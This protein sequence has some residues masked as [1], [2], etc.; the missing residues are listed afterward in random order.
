MYVC[1]HVYVYT[2]T[3]FLLLGDPNIDRKLIFKS[4]W[5]IASI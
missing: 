5:K 1:V 2:H 4:L 3:L